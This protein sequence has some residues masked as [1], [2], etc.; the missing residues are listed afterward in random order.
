MPCH[1]NLESYLH[2][3]I[4]ACELASDPKGPLFRTLSRATRQ[5]R[6]PHSPR[7]TLMQ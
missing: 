2:A 7:R 4:N 3:Y 1:H 5:L 6:P